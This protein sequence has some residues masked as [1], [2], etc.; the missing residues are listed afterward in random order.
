MG[1]HTWWDK[2]WIHVVD[3]LCVFVLACGLVVLIV[4]SERIS[5]D[6]RRRYEESIAPIWPRHVRW[7][8]NHRLNLD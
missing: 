1:S 6:N 4:V 2:N 3:C 5:R 8:P 7:D